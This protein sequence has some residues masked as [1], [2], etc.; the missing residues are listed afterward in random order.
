MRR[1]QCGKHVYSYIHAAPA[2]AR[3]EEKEGNPAPQAAEGELV[4]GELSH[5]K[6]NST[7][8]TIRHVT[9]FSLRR[10]HGISCL[11]S[12][13][14]FKTISAS[15]KYC[16]VLRDAPF[17]RRTALP[18]LRTV[19]TPKQ[20]LS[21]RRLEVISMRR[22]LLGRLFPYSPKLSC[23]REKDGCT[24]TIYRVPSAGYRCPSRSPHA[25]ILWI[26]FIVECRFRSQLVSQAFSS[27]AFVGSYMSVYEALVCPACTNRWSR[28]VRTASV[29]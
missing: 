12:I 3:I 9:R 8:R 28:R 22:S 17:D 1:Y 6:Q 21:L 14:T 15:T 16:P 18:F 26:T 7:S 5:F 24:G 23:F 27:V 11:A 4:L 13:L 20:A 29:P 10:L 19:K 25:L 2:G